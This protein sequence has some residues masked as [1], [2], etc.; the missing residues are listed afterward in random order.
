MIEVT[1]TKTIEDMGEDVTVLKFREPVFGD[2]MACKDPDN[3]MAVLAIIIEKC[4]NLTPMAVKQ[5]SLKDIKKIGEAL[6]PFL[7]L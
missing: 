3:D 6:K 7:D 2:L 1:L 4:A 5:I